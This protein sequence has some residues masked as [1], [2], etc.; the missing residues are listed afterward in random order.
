MGFEV[1]RQK[2]GNSLSGRAVVNKAI[3]EEI[4]GGGK[5]I[6]ILTEFRKKHVQNVY[7]QEFIDDVFEKLL[8]ANQEMADATLGKDWKKDGP[9]T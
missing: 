2:Y 9:N 5:I 4:P 1:L 7:P 8:A 6:D 3:R